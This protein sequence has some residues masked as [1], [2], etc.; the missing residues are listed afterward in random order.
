MLNNVFP[1]FF[2][3]GRNA[4]FRTGLDAEINTRSVNQLCVSGCLCVCVCVCVCVSVSVCLCVCVC[5]CVCVC[6]CVCVSVC[7]RV[8]VRACVRV[9]VCCL[10]AVS[11]LRRPEAPDLGLVSM[12]RAAGA[13][14]VGTPYYQEG[15]L[16]VRIYWKKRGGTTHNYTHT[17][18]QLT[19]V[20]PAPS[21]TVAPSDKQTEL[22]TVLQ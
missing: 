5:V 8:C 18:H 17:Q 14:E 21:V 12:K 15:Q 6:L 3:T 22:L 20:S 13:L 16:Q 4:S 11:K 19:S 1:N 2:S 10:G 9:C 7:V